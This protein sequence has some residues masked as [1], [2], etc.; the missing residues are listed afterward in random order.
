MTDPLSHLAF[1]L[2]GGNGSIDGQPVRT[3]VAAGL[4]LLRGA[5]AL[6]RALDRHRSALW[7]PPGAAWVAAMAA[8][9]GRA[10][11]LVE[12]GQSRDAI[13]ALLHAHDVGA[14][15]TTS[16]RVAMLP[17]GLPHVALDHLP[18]QAQWCD[19]AGRA[20]TIPLVTH[21]GLQLEGDPEAEG[22]AE[23]VWRLVGAD[24]RVV[25]MSHR[26]VLGG[27]RA[28]AADA[29]LAPRDHALVLGA[30]VSPE[31]LVHGIVAP[32]L[33]GGRVTTLAGRSPVAP[34]VAPEPPAL[35]HALA[36]LEAD[37]VSLLVSDAV[38]YDALLAAL[39]ARGRPL[40]APVLQ[41]CIAAD[42]DGPAGA[43]SPLDALARR[44]RAGTGLPLLQRRPD[45]DRARARAG[46]GS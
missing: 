37:G 20:H 17:P 44:W 3:L 22:S 43:P 18:R 30:G 27:A 25:P 16:D 10:A 13:A 32:L 21:H 40:D 38:G 7:L 24:R 28:F 12:G 42:G 1:A 4:A 6:V 8:S 33:A 14:V 15:F 36:T 29:R 26:E 5:P 19:T 2:A 34:D 39:E 11:L 9:E 46:D 35:T 41:R 31:A 45:D 23:E